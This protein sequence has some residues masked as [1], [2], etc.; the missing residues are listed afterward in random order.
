MKYRSLYTLVAL[1]ACGTLPIVGCDYELPQVSEP[2][3]AGGENSSSSSG[4]GAAAGQ[5]G[6]GGQGGGGSCTPG[7]TDVCAPY[8]GP[9]GTE[10]VGTCLA[11]T[12]T[13]SMSGSWTGC[14][15]EVLPTP[16]NC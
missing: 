12:N 11:S 4:Q 14:V 8:G 9:S 1:T 5:T 16:E 15:Q 2:S 3:G 6:S 7:T 13:C 10:G